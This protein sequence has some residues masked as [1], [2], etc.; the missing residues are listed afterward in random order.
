M[1]STFAMS[2]ITQVFTICR[3]LNECDVFEPFEWRKDF[4]STTPKGPNRLQKHPHPSKTSRYF[5][6]PL[7]ILIFNHTYTVLFENNI[8]I[9][10]ICKL[11]LAFENWHHIVN[12]TQ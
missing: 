11:N 1:V 10:C 6:Y 2:K 8:H 4:Q 9:L 5:P 12:L 7:R 3:L